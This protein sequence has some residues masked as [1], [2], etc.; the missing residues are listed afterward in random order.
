MYSC[1]FF[2]ANTKIQLKIIAD[3]IRLN[4]PNNTACC[5]RNFSGELIPHY[6]VSHWYNKPAVMSSLNINNPDVGVTD[7]DQ[8]IVID[9]VDIVGEIMVV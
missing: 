5:G 8:Y 1:V 9:G 3:F 4:D 7:G 2:P 6:D